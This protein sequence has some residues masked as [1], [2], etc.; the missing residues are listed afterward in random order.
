M[1]EDKRDLLV[2]RVY[3]YRRLIKL[4]D[5]DLVQELPSYNVL[6]TDGFRDVSPSAA[7]LLALERLRCIAEMLPTEPGVWFQ[8]AWHSFAYPEDVRDYETAHDALE[9][10]LRLRPDDVAAHLAFAFLYLQREGRKFTED[11]VSAQ[12]AWGGA[13]GAHLQAAIT[14]VEHQL[15]GFW[16]CMFRVPFVRVPFG[17]WVSIGGTLNLLSRKSC[18]I[19]GSYL[20]AVLKIVP[21]DYRG[22]FCLLASY[23][24]DD[25]STRH[26]W[27]GMALD[28]ISGNDMLLFDVHWGLAYVNLDLYGD[29]E[30]ALARYFEELLKASEHLLRLPYDLPGVANRY[31]IWFQKILD[32]EYFLE[33]GKSGFPD[34]AKMQNPE[35]FMKVTNASLRLYEKQTR[36]DIHTDYKLHSLVAEAGRELKDG[37]D[38]RRAKS[39]FQWSRDFSEQLVRDETP[40]ILDEAAGILDETSIIFDVR[41][42]L[43]L[44]QRHLESVRL[45]PLYSAVALR[46]ILI[47]EG[48]YRGA[49][50]ENDYVLRL[51]PDDPNPDKPEP[52]RGVLT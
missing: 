25:A 38:L 49:Q 52:N 18:D 34:P 15:E 14:A 30:I 20:H 37:G 26:A 47:Q 40:R 2:D 19:L 46:D 10:T 44:R 7:R 31:D 50:I 27:L 33:Q 45:L 43:E 4:A 17:E 51:V 9:Q 23:A 42:D 8:I 16:S 22:R 1:E 24:L 13:I 12:D 41:R 35:L 39:Y 5:G 6:M 21:E 28:W 48:D 36:K 11:L 3:E 29:D 32:D